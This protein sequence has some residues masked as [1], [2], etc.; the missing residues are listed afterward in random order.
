M[1]SSGDRRTDIAILAAGVAAVS[2]AAIF[3][4][5]ADAPALVIAAYRLTLA[6]APLLALQAL[7]RRPMLPAGGRRRVLLT[8]LAGVF[9]AAHFGFWIASVQDTSII[10]SVVL[11]TAQP[12]FVAAASGPLLGERPSPLAWAGIVTA[13]AGGAVMIAEDVGQGTDALRGDA[14]ALLGAAFAAAYI[15]AGRRLRATGSEWLP[16][17]TTV[18]STAAAV[19]VAAALIAGHSPTG[20]S[21]ES[22]LFFALLALVPQLIGHT[23]INRSLGYLPAASVAIAILGEP[24]GSTVLGAVF[25]DEVPT[26]LQ[27]AGA[28]IVLTGVYAGLR[29]SL[30]SGEPAV[31]PD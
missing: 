19:L 9:L 13:G 25:L 30:R 4:R 29:G 21:A 14:F 7:R 17:V 16:Y 23:A 5:Q 24:I 2:T 15:L 3:I 28:A 27:L 20:Y 8:L 22:Y 10:T 26:A 31:A 18:Y 6:S 11:V 12:L 1:R